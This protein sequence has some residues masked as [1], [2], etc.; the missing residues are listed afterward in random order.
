M[1][2]TGRRADN[3]PGAVRTSVSSDVPAPVP[4][5]PAH[6]Y[7]KSPNS[8]ACA[9]AAGAAVLRTASSARVGGVNN[10]AAVGCVVGECL[11]NSE[12]VFFDRAGL[13]GEG[14][15]EVRL[16]PDFEEVAATGEDDFGI[17]GD[18]GFF[19][20]IFWNEELALVVQGHF[21]AEHR[22]LAEQEGL[23]SRLLVA[24]FDQGHLL[25]VGILAEHLHDGHFVSERKLKEKRLVGLRTPSS[26]DGNPKLRVHLVGR[27]THVGCRGGAH[28]LA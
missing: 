26:R 2:V 7:E 11:E 23:F 1:K 17:G 13:D 16:A 22:E 9:R 12:I 14:H 18:A 8:G 3:Q 24:A 15:F 21:A 6:P 4:R 25:I 19:T 10:I 5:N 28:W 27:V 20:E